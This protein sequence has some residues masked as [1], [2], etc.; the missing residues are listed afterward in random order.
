MT[1]TTRTTAQTTGG[2][3]VRGIRG[4]GCEGPHHHQEDFTI[5]SL[6]VVNQYNS[7]DFVFHPIGMKL[8]I[9]VECILVQWRK[10]GTVRFIGIFCDYTHTFCNC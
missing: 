2:G 9:D 4:R 5:F 10:L 8:E 6:L 7:K 3:G 1:T